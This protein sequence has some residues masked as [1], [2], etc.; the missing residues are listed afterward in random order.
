[1]AS[2]PVGLL[3]VIP[4]IAVPLASKLFRP[5]RYEPL[6]AVRPRFVRRR[7]EQK[8]KEKK[9]QERKTT[10]LQYQVYLSSTAVRV[11]FPS[12]AVVRAIEASHEACHDELRQNPRSQSCRFSSSCI[13]IYTGYVYT[14]YEGCGVKYCCFCLFW[15]R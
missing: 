14:Y 4:T 11:L 1:M 9:K 10:K 5:R 7:Q 6:S 2:K 13:Y 15:K 8:R 12:K 3:A